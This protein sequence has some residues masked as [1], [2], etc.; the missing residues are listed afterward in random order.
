MTDLEILKEM[1]DRAH[2]EY[3]E[4]TWERD[5][6]KF[7]VLTVERGYVGFATEFQ[8]AEDTGRLADMGAYE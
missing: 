1:L 2:I 4:T 8:F 7:N 3:D 6:K 5:G